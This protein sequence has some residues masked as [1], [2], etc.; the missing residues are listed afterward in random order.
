MRITSGRGT[1]TSPV[2]APDGTK[3]VYQHTDAHNSA[4]LFIVDV[5]A[6]TSVRLSDSMPA[7]IDRAAF[8]EPQFV[9]YPG[10]DGQQV[11][12][13]LF[14]P[15]NLDRTRKHPAIVWIHG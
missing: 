12:G 7:S 14:V 4:D 15:K 2:W 1:D 8:V 3:I 5:A 6:R 10:P 13:W 11:P 9:H